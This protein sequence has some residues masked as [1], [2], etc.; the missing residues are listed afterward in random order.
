MLPPECESQQNRLREPPVQK[1][2][3]DRRDM[4]AAVLGTK[5]PA[6]RMAMRGPPEPPICQRLNPNN[7]AYDPVFAAE[8]RTR[9]AHKDPHYLYSK[10]RK[11]QSKLLR[12]VH[13]VR[14]SAFTAEE[15]DYLLDLQGE[16]YVC[17]VLC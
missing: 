5:T 13:W 4:L 14:K 9:R 2:Y 10:A 6:D 17:S 12:R 15:H 1:G 8:H 16:C 7:A 3:P 11:Q